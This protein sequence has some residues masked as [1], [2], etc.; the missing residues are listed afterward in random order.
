[1]PLSQERRCNRG[2][3]IAHATVELVK[4]ARAVATFDACAA[5]LPQRDTGST[6][7]RKTTS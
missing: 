2:A 6:V 1:V 3:L 7:H 4:I 5:R